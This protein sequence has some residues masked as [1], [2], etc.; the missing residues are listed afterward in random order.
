M[1][2]I[3]EFFPAADQNVIPAGSGFKQP[4]DA[5]PGFAQQL[6]DR[7]HHV[8]RLDL[9]ERRQPGLPQQR[10]VI[11]GHGTS[12][13][14][15]GFYYDSIDAGT[16][17]RGYLPEFLTVPDGRASRSDRTRLSPDHA[18]QRCAAIRDRIASITGLVSTRRANQMSKLSAACS[19]SIPRPS[20]TSQR[21]SARHQ[22]LKAVTS[23]PYTMS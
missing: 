3:L 18:R 9:P 19:T 22:R 12:F 23:L 8:F 17:S 13:L 15:D 11:L 14:Y 20:A 4:R 6:R 5:R 10:I 16:V 21:A 2:A 7:R 1:Q